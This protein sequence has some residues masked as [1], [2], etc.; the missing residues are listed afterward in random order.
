MG[1]GYISVSGSLLLRRKEE[2]EINGMAVRIPM[3]F[4]KISFFKKKY[5]GNTAKC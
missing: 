5:E 3:L 4:I 2:K 1:E